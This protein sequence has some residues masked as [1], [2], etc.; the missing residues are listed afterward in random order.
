LLQGKAPKSELNASFGKL[1]FLKAS[2]YVAEVCKGKINKK[3]HSIYFS[4]F[5][6]SIIIFG[7][8]RALINFFS[9]VKPDFIGK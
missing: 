8:T 4:N 3:N 2:M 6:M 7:S 9:C 5:Y 1:C